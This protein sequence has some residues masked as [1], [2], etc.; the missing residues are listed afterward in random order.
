LR[1]VADDLYGAL[2]GRDPAPVAPAAELLRI[3]EA[4]GEYVLRMALP[5]AE[6]A[7]VDAVRVGDDL[8]VTV[9]P[10]RRVI[11][12]P[13]LLRRATVAGGRFDGEQ[14]RVRFRPPSAPDEPPSRPRPRP[15]PAGAHEKEADGD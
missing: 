8:V 14:L 10:N 9:G 5:L 12:L 11:T 15:R 13:S 6:R 7:A 4:D 2:P 1:E 3:E